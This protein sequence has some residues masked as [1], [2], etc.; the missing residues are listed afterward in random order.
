[1]I[2]SVTDFGSKVQQGWSQN[3]SAGNK[4]D[5]L[6]CLRQP[7]DLQNEENMN[8]LQLLAVFPN[9]GIFHICFTKTS[10]ISSPNSLAASNRA[11]MALACYSSLRTLKL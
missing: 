8:I 4:W 7:Q 10:A 5:V 6:A 9:F 11:L 1:M 3:T 2:S